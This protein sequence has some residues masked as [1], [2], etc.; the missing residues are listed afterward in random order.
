MKAAI[1]GGGSIGLL[2][3]AYLLQS[4]MDVS[5]IVR[6]KEQKTAIQND[7][8][9]LKSRNG[10]YT[11]QPDVH[12]LSEVESITADVLIVAVK[13]YQVADIKSEIL[14]KYEQ[15]KSILFVQNGMHHIKY[16]P[17]LKNHS[18]YLGIVEH[19]SLKESDTCIRHTGIGQTRIAPYIDGHSGINWEQHSTDS[20]AF[21]HHHDWYEML[22]E[23]L[24]INSVINPLTA[25]LGVENG[26]LL[27]NPDW[28][29]LMKKLSAESC[30]VLHIN[31]S[32]AWKD[33]LTVCKN[34]SLNKSSMLR[35]IEG[36]RK[37][38]IEA[39]NGY[40]VDLASQEQI[41]VSNHEFVYK[42]IKGMEM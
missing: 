11:F 17:D 18:I 33:L 15:R 1:I 29:D 25:I 30:R 9:K 40:L 19:G 7:G 2:F 37:T 23:K 42:M 35:D 10:Q 12:L 21:V 4:G 5:L 27:D 20:F 8:L 6:R 16:L 22:S 32:D 28:V 36:R 13:S 39:I 31:E 34:T 26:K 14:T 38:E 3:T 41:D 24:H